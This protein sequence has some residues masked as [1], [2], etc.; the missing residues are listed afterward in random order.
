VAEVFLAVVQPVV[1]VRLLLLLLEMLNLEWGK[2]ISVLVRA[3]FITFYRK[4]N[5]K[6]I[7]KFLLSGKM[8]FF[9]ISNAFLINLQ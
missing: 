6:N 5:K 4:N 3:F 9:F 8:R 7:F 2:L 1:V